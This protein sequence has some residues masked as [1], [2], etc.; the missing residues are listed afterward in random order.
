M[1]AHLQRASHTAG[2]LT[3]LYGPGE[4]GSHINPR[5]IA[6]DGH[7]APIEML[8]KPETLPYLAHA[9][10]APV[11]RLGARAPE[12]P[13]WVCSVRSDPRRPDLTD[14]QWADVAR[15]VVAATGIAPDG[16]PDACRWIALRNQPHRVYV[17][18]TLAREDGSLHNAYRDAF[19]LQTECQ[20]IA[21]DLGHLPS[22]PSPT[23]RAQE[24]LV[25]SPSITITTEPS[26]SISAKGAN[27]DLSATLLKH[28]GFQQIQDW[29]GRRH[30]LPTTTPTA[31]RSA[32]ATHATEM[33]RAA[34]YTVDL[35]PSLDTN[36]S[37]TPANLLGPY[38]AGAEILRLTD[39]IRAAESR[40]ELQQAVDHLLHPEHGALER[41][42]EA[43]EAAGE[44][45]SDLDDEAYAVADRF[46]VAAE[47]VCAAQS[48]LFG[49]ETELQ[50][51]DDSQ[52]D[53][54]EARTLSPALPGSRIAALA[55]SPAAAKAKASSALGAGAQEVGP[56]VRP[57]QVPGPRTR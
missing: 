54:V 17:V 34:R 10:D 28:A 24:T 16:D 43:L 57:S 47:F 41:V 9:L 50:R 25:P 51:A 20:R 8:A 3:Y 40:A 46:G 53:Q 2:L 32:I 38:T 29:Y 27:D 36:R 13:V 26:G 52:Q 22:A 7:G 30:R 42:R 19:H 12:R 55:T 4:H 44:Q 6:G 33:L 48:E 23:H 56:A 5:L 31:D 21:A 39:Q 49:A 15:R 37:T 18:A 14:S 1:I 11:E 35:D 45:I